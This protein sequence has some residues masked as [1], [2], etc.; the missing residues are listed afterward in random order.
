MAERPSPPT[1]GS[2]IG[3]VVDSFEEGGQTYAVLEWPAPRTTPPPVPRAQRAVLDLLLNGLSNA[4]IALRL[5]RSI[6]TVA[7]QVDTIFRRLGVGSRLELFALVARLSRG[8][9]EP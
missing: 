6:H 4:E 1:L 5:G 9:E 8:Q 2:P 3:L 7:H